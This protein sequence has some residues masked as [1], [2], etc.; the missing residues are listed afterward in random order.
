MQDEQDKTEQP[1]PQRLKQSRDR[2]EV[3]KSSEFTGWL[4]MCAFAIT[5][6]ITAG[7]VAQSV[8]TATSTTL[9][10]SGARADLSS[11][12][13]SVISAVAVPI[14][15]AL[16]P[17]TLAIVV[18]AVVGNIAQAG[19]VLSADPLGPN[20]G[21]MNPTQAIKRVFSVQS[22]FEFAKLMLKIGALIV[23]AWWA[24]KQLDPFVAEA[25]FA[26]PQAL[27][28]A[29]ASIFLNTALWILVPLGVLAVVDLLFVRY[30]HTRKLRMSKREVK[31]EMKQRE[32]DPEIRSKRKRL[33]RE[34]LKR[35]QSVAGV[36][37]ADVVVTNPTH[38]A[39]ALRYR[40]KEMR[41]PVVVAKGAGQ[42]AAII[43]SES[44]RYGVPTLRRPELARRL[45]RETQIDH[46]ISQDAYHDV[47]PIYRWL[48]SRPGQ[49]IV[50]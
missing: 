27:G 14:L 16:M 21:R 26:K 28:A 3:A 33:Q 49:R 48:M 39:V 47:A 46:P 7:S 30:Q 50:T 35:S 2:G 41:A 15:Q 17:L 23:I 9:K 4:V 8:L 29:L 34:L 19:A 32:G 36:S 25:A 10:L 6:A 5:V 13:A 1:T 12:L 40:P 37:D 43:R 42:M 24:F 18:I 11:E 38:I 31:D 22:L 45:Y 44:S 20:F